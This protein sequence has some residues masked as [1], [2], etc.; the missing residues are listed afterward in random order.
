MRL[1]D[2]GH[3]SARLSAKLP[4]RQTAYLLLGRDVPSIPETRSK[5][6]DRPVKAGHNERGGA[7]CCA[8][9]ER[10]RYS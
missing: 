4:Q 3:L 6:D 2:M 10:A 1:D 7:R 8:A 5:V 9:G